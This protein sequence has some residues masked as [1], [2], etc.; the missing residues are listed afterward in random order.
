MGDFLD[1]MWT[2]F[3]CQWRFDNL[4]CVQRVSS[5]IISSVPFGILFCVSWISTLTRLLLI[6][7]HLWTFSVEVW[8]PLL[9]NFFR[10]NSLQCHCKVL[11]HIEVFLLSDSRFR[12]WF[13]QLNEIVWVSSSLSSCVFITKTYCYV[14]FS[15]FYFYFPFVLVLYTFSLYHLAQHPLCSEFWTCYLIFNNLL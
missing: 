3:Y 1:M 10:C 13:M 14:S 9:E 7:F 2:C 6:S 8:Q 12:P 15:S 11:R 4:V 5:F